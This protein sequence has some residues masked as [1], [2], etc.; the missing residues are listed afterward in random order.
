MAFARKTVP[1]P[2]PAP[3]KLLTAAE[4]L[5]RMDRLDFEALSSL[6]VHT[7]DSR[8]DDAYLVLASEWFSKKV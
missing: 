4:L 5:D 3:V 2:K 8:G 1:R 7:A 6:H